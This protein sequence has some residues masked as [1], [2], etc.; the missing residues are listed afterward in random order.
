M[1]TPSF[2]ELS[3]VPSFDDSAL[4]VAA[5]HI[6]GHLIL[7]PTMFPLNLQV[8]LLESFLEFIDGYWCWVDS[9]IYLNL[10]HNTAI[11]SWYT[12]QDVSDPALFIKHMIQLLKLLTCMA[13]DVNQT[14][15]L[16]L[17]SSN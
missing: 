4:I 5:V 15:M 3:I 2:K 6:Q 17:T 11:L 12:C 16:V 13:S 14:V 7:R 10:L 9:S 1:S 8:V